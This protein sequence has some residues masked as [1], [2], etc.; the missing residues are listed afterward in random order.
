MHCGTA[1]IHTHTRLNLIYAEDFFEG[2]EGNPITQPLTL[3]IMSSRHTK[4]CR[5]QNLSQKTSTT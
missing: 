2:S 5:M 3:M 4:L 1:H